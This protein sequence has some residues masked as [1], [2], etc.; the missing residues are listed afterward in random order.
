M[1]ERTGQAYDKVAADME[2]DNWMSSQDALDYG[3]VDKILYPD[4]K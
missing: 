1:S 4:N 2:R 3:I